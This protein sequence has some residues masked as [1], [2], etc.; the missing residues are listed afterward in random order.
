MARRR[1]LFT[2]TRYLFNYSTE[3]LPPLKPSIV[4]PQYAWVKWSYLLEQGQTLRHLALRALQFD[5]ADEV[6]LLAL[7]FTGVAQGQRVGLERRE[8]NQGFR[9][10]PDI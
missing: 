7:I 8:R 2:W 10:N 4:R 1:Q 9:A 5:D 3:S 6:R